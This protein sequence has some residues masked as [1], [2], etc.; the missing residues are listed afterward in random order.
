MVRGTALPSLTRQRRILV[1]PQWAVTIVAGEAGFQKG[2]GVGVEISA[3]EAVE[4]P[5]KRVWPPM[6]RLRTLEKFW[7]AGLAGEERTSLSL[8]G[9]SLNTGSSVEEGRE[10]VCFDA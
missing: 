4:P 7:E 1:S 3:I 9:R 10:G 6:G 8:R 2:V 5:W